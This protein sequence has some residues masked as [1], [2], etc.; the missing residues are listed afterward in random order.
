M[1]KPEWRAGAPGSKLP[2]RIQAGRGVF[3]GALTGIARLPFAAVTTP[4]TAGLIARSHGV[5]DPR[6]SPS[7]NRLAWTDSFDGRRD[8]V[9]AAADGSAPPT[10]VTAECA[11]GAGWCWAGDDE[12]VIVAGDGRLLAIAPDGTPRRVLHG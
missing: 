4:I 6:W 2:S 1:K 10:V 8:L 12:L 9:V 3:T 7:G 5:G 11:L